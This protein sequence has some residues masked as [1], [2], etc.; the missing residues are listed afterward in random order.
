MNERRLH[1]ALKLI[2]LILMDTRQIRQR[3]DNKL[4]TEMHSL[5]LQLIEVD[6]NIVM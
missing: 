2:S 4:C 1:D 5:E 6:H 3:I